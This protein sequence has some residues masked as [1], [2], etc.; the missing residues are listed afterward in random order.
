MVKV[1]KGAR[2]KSK[3]PSSH[4]KVQRGGFRQK[5]LSEF[6]FENQL[7]S[8]TNFLEFTN[9]SPEEVRI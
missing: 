2:Y 6:N 4:F 9:V 3:A 7:Y 1:K 8:I 5:Y